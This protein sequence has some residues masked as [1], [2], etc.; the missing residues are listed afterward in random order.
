MG[1]TL[2]I[3]ALATVLGVAAGMGADYLEDQRE[4]LVDEGNCAQ[5]AWECSTHIPRTISHRTFQYADEES[6]RLAAIIGRGVYD[7]FNACDRTIAI[8][9]E[10]DVAR[11]RVVAEFANQFKGGRGQLAEVN[12]S[13]PTLDDLLTSFKHVADNSLGFHCGVFD[14]EFFSEDNRENYVSVLD[15]YAQGAKFDYLP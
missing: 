7:S 2:K 11:S 1:T 14:P 10:L 15:Q 8:S 12:W 3:T 4:V 9:V 5:N 13:P 6:D